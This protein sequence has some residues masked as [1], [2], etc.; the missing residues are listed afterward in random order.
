MRFNVAALTQAAEEAARRDRAEWTRLHASK[1]EE[2]EKRAQDWSE[3]YAAEWDEAALAIRRKLRKHSPIVQ[4]DL[5]SERQT[6]HSVAV[7]Y[8][9]PTGQWSDRWAEPSELSALRAVLATLADDTVT[10]AGLRDLGIST[11]TM[12]KVVAHL[13][14]GTVSDRKGN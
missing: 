3:K 14:A 13:R 2:E 4:A 12:Q 7:F 10:S 9:R 8:P 6:I 1:I 5:P 11:R